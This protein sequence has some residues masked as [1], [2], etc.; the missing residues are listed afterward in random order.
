MDE[1]RQIT[2]HALSLRKAR[3]LRVRLPLAELTVVTARPEAL[4]PFVDILREEL[5]V[6]T[7]VLVQQTESSAADH[8]IVHTLSVN[9]RAAGPRLGKQVQQVIKAAKSGDWSEVDGVVT[10]G[11]ITLEAHEYELTLNVG[12]SGA[13]DGTAGPALTLIPGGGFVLLET[14]TTPELEA[15]GIAR[16]AI[17]AVQEARKNAGLEVSDRIGLALNA[18]PEHAAALETFSGL[19]ASETLATAIAVEATTQAESLVEEPA[20]NI[21]GEIFISSATALGTDK[22]ALIITIDASQKLK[23]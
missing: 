10:A 6:K 14:E 15:E 21:D 1:V 3:K 18:A 19:I 8:G 12:G 2:S 11:G 22:A 9:A 23:G 17:R 16:D 13:A 4:S 20:R 5:N 7:V